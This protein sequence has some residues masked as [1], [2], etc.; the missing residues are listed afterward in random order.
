MHAITGCL[1]ALIA[2]FADENPVTL[3]GIPPLAYTFK[4]HDPSLYTL[5]FIWTSLHD[6]ILPQVIV[7]DKS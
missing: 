7:V 3:T 4:T 1:S 2:S 6:V 5:G